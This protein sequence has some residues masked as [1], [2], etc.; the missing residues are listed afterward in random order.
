MRTPRLPTRDEKDLMGKTTGS[1]KVGGQE[2]T[3]L[4]LASEPENHGNVVTN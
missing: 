4:Q 2:I 3:P 1:M